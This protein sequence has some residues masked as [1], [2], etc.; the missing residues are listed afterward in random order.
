MEN[1]SKLQ[2]RVIAVLEEAGE[3]DLATLLNTVDNWRGTSVEV[4]KIRDALTRMLHYELIKVA[5]IRDNT[6]LLWTPLTKEGALAVLQQ[7][8]RCLQWCQDES[9][10]RWKG[11]ETRPTVLLT[12]SG[13]ALARRVLSEDG[14]P[15]D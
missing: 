10:W 13:Q 15:S 14:W 3:E 4:E 2:R 12:D 8:G 1:L 6:T 11:G 5:S 9:L 7:L